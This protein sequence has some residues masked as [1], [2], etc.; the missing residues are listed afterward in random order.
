MAYKCANCGSLSTQAQFDTYQCV[1][2]GYRT[3]YEGN[4]IAQGNKFLVGNLADLQRAGGAIASGAGTGLADGVELPPDTSPEDA[5]AS[6][7]EAQR[8]DPT[9]PDPDGGDSVTTSKSTAK[10]KA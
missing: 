5:K 8:R 10:K 7:D 1:D 6:A 2:C 4:V 9:K 3:D